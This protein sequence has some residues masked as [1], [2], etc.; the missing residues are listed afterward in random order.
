MTENVQVTQRRKAFIISLDGAT[1]EVLRPLIEQGCLPNLKAAMHNGFAAELESVV[2]AVTA[3]AW[4]SF[5]TGKHPSKHGIFGFTRFDPHDY[6]WK[7]NNA[8]HIC[9][10]TIWQVL[11]EKGRR[12]VVLNLPYTYPPYPIN[13]ILVCGW[14]SVSARFTY[15]PDLSQQILKTMP[16][17]D[18]NL[19]LCDVMPAKSDG[20][21]NQFVNKLIEG[22][23]QSTELALHFL[24]EE[25]WDVFMVHFQQSDWIQHKLWG[26][27]QKACDDRTDKS[28]R[29]EKVRE[30]YKRLDECVG[31]LL[32]KVA[33]QNPI[34]IILS[35]HG[36]GCHR[37]I[38]YPNYYLQQ[39]GFLR[40][41]RENNR[42]SFKPLKDLF[43]KSR[44]NPVRRLYK[45][46]SEA[47]RALEPAASLEKYKQYDSWVDFANRTFDGRRLPVDWQ[48]T[49]VA[50]VETYQ[51]AFL[52]VNLKR[53]GR[54]GIVEPGLQYERL[55]DDLI[56]RF[57]E[58][59]H[60]DTGTK[61][62]SG[63]ARGTDVYPHVNP[64]VWLPDVILFP[65]DGYNFSNIIADAAPEPTSEGIHRP[66]GV[67]IMQG[68]GL[69][70]PPP[71][72]APKLID[73]TP[74]LLHLLGLAVPVD[75]DG[76]VLEEV[77]SVSGQVSYEDVDNSLA[78]G[79]QGDYSVE[80]SE[81]IEQRLK[82]LGYLE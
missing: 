72:F 76:R 73:I 22:A 14:D 46:L 23:M 48:H 16:E 35:D 75:M 80:D 55:V 74:T 21:C 79:K 17:Y 61:L 59:R 27:I 58:I 82:S 50:T 56:S 13:G 6:A 47:R 43:R 71:G 63:V 10:K 65:A 20:D 39:W 60:P 68:E 29:V 81:M 34:Q 41:A 15:P 2:P 70:P 78:P 45:T 1:F 77:I 30:F 12:V 49:Q 7:L 37:G 32:A 54:Q 67:L 53:R 42:E 24:D 36:F 11:S 25:S 51:C 26:A 57:S 3:P 8:Q 66:M 69:T 19:W 33:R 40:P 18:P 44:F 9:S 28:T 64:N 52:Y 4:T 31:T 38:I 62:L 5:M